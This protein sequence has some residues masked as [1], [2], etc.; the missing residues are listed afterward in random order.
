MTAILPRVRA[1]MDPS[2]ATATEALLRDLNS[3][4]A[5]NS[6]SRSNDSCV[7]NLAADE[8]QEAIELPKPYALRQIALRLLSKASLE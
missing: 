3:K 4:S 5:K 8:S 6:S 1:L 7:G 2:D